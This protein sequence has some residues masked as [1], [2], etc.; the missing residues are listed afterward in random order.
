MTVSLVALSRTMPRTAPVVES[1]A[2]ATPW[3][4]HSN[5][6]TARIEAVLTNL[7]VILRVPGGSGLGGGRRGEREGE[8]L[9]ERQLAAGDV[10]DARIDGDRVGRLRVERR[11]RADGQDVR[12]L[13]GLRVRGVGRRERDGEGHVGAA[14]VLQGEGGHRGGRVDRRVQLEVDGRRR[15]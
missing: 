2:W 14:L 11:V 4:A 13:A 9:V 10:G 7:M 6:T 15:I 1:C 5:P 3:V 8:R 12:E